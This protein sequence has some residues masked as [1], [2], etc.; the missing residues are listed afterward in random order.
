M[1]QQTKQELE[2]QVRGMEIAS[3]NHPIKRINKLNYKIR[4]QSNEE[5]W[6]NV[7]KKY[8]S[9]LGSRQDGQWICTCPDYRFRQIQCKHIC[10]ILFSKKIRGKVISQDVAPIIIGSSDS[11][12]CL[13]CKSE[14]IVKDGNRHNKKGLSQK[15]LCREC[16]YRFVVNTGFEN[17]KKEPKLICACIDLYFKGMSL[18]KV[19]DHVKQFYGVSIS[20]VSVLR[21]VQRFADV[22]SPFVNSLSPP[23]LGGVF[24]VDEMVVHVRREEIGKGHYQ[25]LWNF[26][27]DSTR[28]WVS[29]MVSQ[30]REVSDARNVF[31]D[32]KSKIGTTHAVIHD[33]LPSYNEAF[34]K[35]FYTIKNPRV[36]NIRSISVRNE[37]LNSRVERLNGTMR[38]R[39]KVM[40]G[41]NTRESSQ[42]IIEAMRIHYNFIREHS[43]LGKTP[44]EQAGI[45]LEL[46][47]NKIE[48]L[49]KIATQN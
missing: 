41:M 8:G 24:Q 29:S 6:Y 43:S 10:A 20:N 17:S 14:K 21:W 25:W 38:D 15:Y 30:R 22:V 39:E 5:I 45:K 23:H 34:Q 4:S 46:G 12:E 2:R 26:M 42:K 47:E 48:S 40:R 28:F 31:A 11:I 18:R 44:A 27:D 19:A 3:V 7:T 37:G 35:E 32:A 1:Y 36:K 33:G 9:N 49:F 16:G 13:K